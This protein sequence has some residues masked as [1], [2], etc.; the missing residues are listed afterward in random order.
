M[1]ANI[2]NIKRQWMYTLPTAR[3]TVFIL[4]QHLRAYGKREDTYCMNGA[5]YAVVEA[6]TD[7]VIK[8]ATKY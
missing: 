5:V 8:I 7:L 1:L 4:M 3:M 6:T 2:C